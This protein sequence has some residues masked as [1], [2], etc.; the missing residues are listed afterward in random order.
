M[1]LYSNEIRSETM[2][3]SHASPR[4]RASQP[5]SLPMLLLLL[6]LLIAVGV[7]VGKRVGQKNAEVSPLPPAPTESAAPAAVLS[8][9]EP[10]EKYAQ[11]QDFLISV[12]GDNTLASHQFAG[13]TVT[14]AARMGD[15]YAYPYSNTVQYFENDDFTIT[16]LECTL[17]DDKNLR[18]AEQWYFKSPSAYAQILTEGGVDFV[19]TA[20][21]HMGDFGEKG[22]QDT[23]AALEEYGIAYGKEDDFKVI[24]TDSGLVIGVYCA[25]NHLKPLLGHAEHAIQMLKNAGCEYIICAFHWGQELYYTPNQDQI[26]LAHAC[27]DA[28]ADLIYGSHTH[29]LQPIERYGDGYILYSM[30]NWSFGGSTGPTDPDTAIIQVNVHRDKDGKCINKE[31]NII[32]CCVSPKPVLEG[33]RGDNYNDYC[34]TPYT[35]GSEAYERVLSKLDGSYEAKVQGRDYSDVYAQYG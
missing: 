11:E 24:T 15:D 25:Y 8:P 27:I 20:N 16:N 28:G 5:P 29:C 31:L 34:P 30:G 3:N 9:A 19:T 12:I 21:N 14:F 35:E 2:K 33:Y 7:A 32:P 22:E 17:S 13:A 4:R 1:A 10:A 26:D 18:S 23:Y 6:V